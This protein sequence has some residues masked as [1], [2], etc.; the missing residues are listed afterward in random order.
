MRQKLVLLVASA[1]LVLGVAAV[2]AQQGPT[3][4]G[5]VVAANLLFPRGITLGDDGNLYVA[6]AGNGGEEVLL[7]DGDLQVT[8]GYTGHVVQIAP[9]GTATTLL[10]FPSV[11]SP[12]GGN[13]VYRVYR[14]GDELWMTV[15]DAGP[16]G[17]FA[18]LFG[19][20]YAVDVNTG[21]FTQTIDL[22]AAEAEL[23]PDGTEEIYSNVTDLG[24]DADGNLYILDTGANALYT[25][26]E[27]D[28]LDVFH[29]WENVVPTAVEFGDDGTIYVGFLGTE[30]APGAAMVEQWSADGELLETYSGYTGITDI[31]LGEDG[32]IYAVELFTLDPANPEIPGP[33]RVIEVTADG[34]VVVEEGFP[35][36]HSLT[37]GEDGRLYV[38]VGSAQFGPP[39][40]GAVVALDVAE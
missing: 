32:T 31:E 12:E 9:D 3:M 2:S 37:F 40:P 15:S 24:W 22:A 39:V 13:G 29:A 23:N 33:G 8:A 4:P 28:G 27:A 7:E 11:G 5:E 10:A 19:N 14:N 18:P 6:E 30:I 1:A 26:T 38:T 35:L 36:P 34:A 16:V 21:R 17:S 25:W 20:V